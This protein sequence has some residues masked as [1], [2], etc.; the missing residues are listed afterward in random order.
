M[1]KSLKE[2]IEVASTNEESPQS[3]HVSVRSELAPTSLLI[4]NAVAAWGGCEYAELSVVL[5][6]L[7]YL[8]MLHQTHHW[9]AKGDSFHGDHELF[10][11]LYNRI[12][13]EIDGVAEKAVGVGSENNVLL[14]LQL[15]Q[16][17]QVCSMYNSPQT[18]PQSSDLAK[19]SLAAEW[20]F[21][22]ILTAATESMQAN[23]SMTPGIENMV[24]TVFD[25]HEKHIYLLKRRCSS[26][27]LGF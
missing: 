23:G 16:L 27:P 24:Q 18:V 1:K 3:M 15:T 17:T 10:E 12:V 25:T 26:A 21:L 14:Q 4:D 22:K 8:S 6:Y 11:K 9:I 20:N 13:P 7:R 5:V 2:W 19:A